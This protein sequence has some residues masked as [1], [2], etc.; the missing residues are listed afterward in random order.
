MS[1]IKQSREGKAYQSEF[2]TRMRGTG[3]Y[4]EML[5]V[6]HEAAC[7]RLGLDKKRDARRLDCSQFQ[8]PAKKKETAQLSLF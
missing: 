4:A 1:L 3:P 2:G 8:A 5:R 7:H 6:R